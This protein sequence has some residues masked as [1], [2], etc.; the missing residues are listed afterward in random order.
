[1]IV[2]PKEE[3]HLKQHT[4]EPD[5]PALASHDFPNPRR[6]TED[7]LNMIFEMRRDM[8]DQLHIQHTLN[9]RLDMLFDSLS[10]EP[11]KSRFPTCCQS[12]SFTVRHD[13][14]LSSP[15]I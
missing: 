1:M 4:G 2:G 8:A 6:L 7:H 3:T 14:S 9:R 15:Q 5:H 12:F 13:G 11:T 10:S